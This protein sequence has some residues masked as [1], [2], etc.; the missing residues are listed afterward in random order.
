[1]LQMLLYHVQ[2]SKYSLFIH[3]KDRTINILGLFRNVPVLNKS[4]KVFTA[5]EN[6]L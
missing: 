1:M 2:V 6:L 5:S 3:V 4:H